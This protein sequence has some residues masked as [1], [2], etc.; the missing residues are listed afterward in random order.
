MKY[1]SKLFSTDQIMDIDILMDEDDWNNMLENA[2]SEEYY[3]CNVVVKR[4]DLL[5]C[6]NPAKRETQAFPLLQMIRILTGTALSW[7]SIII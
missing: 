2:I 1:E 5:F 3:S 4:Q 7:N 6:W